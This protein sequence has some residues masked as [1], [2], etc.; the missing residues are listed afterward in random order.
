M[1]VIEHHGMFY[2]VLFSKS[3]SDGGRH[4]SEKAGRYRIEI[5]DYL[6]VCGRGC[7]MAGESAVAS[8]CV[9]IDEDY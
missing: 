2:E 7:C 1:K 4:R 3:N 8:W 9:G 5:V 6:T